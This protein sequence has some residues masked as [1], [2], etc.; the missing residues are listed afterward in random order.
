MPDR[1]VCDIC[2]AVL[3]TPAS[4]VVR[5]DVYA[6]P[7]VP[8]VSTAELEEMDVEAKLA[9][10]LKQME[11]MSAEDLQDQV[12]RRFEFRVCASCQRGVIANPLGLPRKVRE[13]EN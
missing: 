2:N 6:D 13:G 1:V 10:L 5:I 8:P 4:Y 9:D 3:H 11:G 7:A 12:H